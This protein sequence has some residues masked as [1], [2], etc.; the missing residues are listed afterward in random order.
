GD[1]KKTGVNAAGC[2]INY[3]IQG[4]QCLPAGLANADGTLS[5]DKVRTK[6]ASGIK[7]SGNDRFHL[8]HN[9][10]GLACGAGE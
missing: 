9:H 2:Y 1:S 3:G 6:F 7:V 4:E 5:C 10:D 8:D